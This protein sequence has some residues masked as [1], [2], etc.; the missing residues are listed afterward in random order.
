MCGIAGFIG[1][2]A[3]KDAASVLAPMLE[4]LHHRGPDGS[5]QWL[6]EAAPVALGHTR[7][8]IVDT[9]EA[10]RQPMHLAHLHASVNGEIYNYPELRRD[11]EAR[12]GAQF[13]S[14]CDSEVVLHGYR[15]EGEAF[16]AR[17]NGMFAVAIYDGEQRKLMLLRDR[18]GIKPLYYC[19]HE[20]N[21][22]FASEIKALLAP[23]QVSSWPID[24]LGLS[25]YLSFQTP[26]AGRTMFAGVSLL[27]PGYMATIHVDTP[28]QISLA[29]YAA[30]PA[31][32][33]VI[34]DYATAVDTFEK[35]FDESIERHLLSDVPI[36]SYISAGLDSTSVA[37]AAANKLRA[38]GVLHAFTGRFPQEIGWYD[39]ASVAAQAVQHFGGVHRTIDITPPD[40]EAHLD[41]ILHALDEPRM[42]MGI[43]SQYMVARKVAAEFKVVLTGHGGDELFAGYPLY[44]LSSWR[45]MRR[46]KLSEL[47]HLVYFLLSACRKWLQP[48][49]GRFLPVLWSRAAQHK[50][51]GRKLQAAEHWQ[52]LA[53]LQSACR[54]RGER[55]EAT[56]LQEYLPNLL[57]VEDRISMAHGLESRTPFLDHRML[58]VS[59]RIPVATKL[60]GGVLKAIIKAHA[61]RHLPPIYMQQPKRGFPTPLRR[62]LRN[63]CASFLEQRLIGESSALPKLV[64]R[65]ALAQELK[66]YQHSWRRHFRPL[67]EIQSHR[68]WQLLSLESWLRQWQTRYNI[69]LVLP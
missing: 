34:A 18:A 29:V 66:R 60:E 2:L 31:P 6:D 49:F 14:H 63:E 11:L 59:A 64:S 23:L 42:G 45:N 7:L 24:A 50:L 38:Q 13:A 4:R 43:F 65:D 69:Q 32:Q 62:W 68:M 30:K 53:Q 33:P 58:D 27:M 9:S 57:I 46:L 3:R 10:G 56:Y 39:E 19:Q 17:M 44:K 15:H 8:A 40:L 67:D 55:I 5:G 61:K 20:G 21:F 1:P 12:Y 37:N 51:L 25:Q 28:Q 22:L 52:P 16:F 54:T 35:T 41:A 48:E 47:P 26:L 36:A